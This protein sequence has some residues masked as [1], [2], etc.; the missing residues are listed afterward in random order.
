MGAGE[1]PM[2]ATKTVREFPICAKPNGDPGGASNASPGSD[3]KPSRKDRLMA[4]NTHTRFAPARHGARKANK[5]PTATVAER[6]RRIDAI[7]AEIE[8]AWRRPYSVLWGSAKLKEVIL[9]A[10]LNGSLTQQDV[11]D[12]FVE[13]G[14][15]EA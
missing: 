1:I 6:L 7:E 10:A 3:R 2:I 13:Y 15:L 8:G 14:L 12:L 4:L 9:D 5:E 11:D